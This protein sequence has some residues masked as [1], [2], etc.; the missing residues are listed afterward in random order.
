MIEQARAVLAANDMG[1][2]VRPGKELYPHQWNWDSAFVALGLAQVEP[3]RGRA[4]VR[5][6]LS[7]QWNDGMVPHIVFHVPAP[8]YFPGAELWD[9]AACEQAPEVPTSG[10]TQPPVLASAV[11][12]LAPGVTGPVVPGGGRPRARA[13]ACVVAQRARYRLGSRRHRP[14]VG[15]RGQLAAL[16]PGARAAGSG[17]RR[18]GHR[19]DGQARDRCLGTADRSGLP[20]LPVPRSAIASARLPA[21]PRGVRRSSS[22]ISPSTR[23]SRR[24]SPTSRGS[25]ASSAETALERALPQSACEGAR[26][27]L[28]R[29]RS[30]IRRGRRR[31][32]DGGRDHRRDVPALC[33]CSETGSGAASLRR[34]VV[35]AD[36]LRAFA[37][38]PV[39][40]DLG[41]EIESRVRSTTLLARSRLG[42]RELVLHPGPR[43]IRAPGRGGRAAADDARARQPVRL[44]RV[45]R[46]QDRRAARRQ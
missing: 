38:R 43:A 42:E 9:S 28:G 23:F 34:G 20:A 12:D 8:D 27:P 25:G 37:R 44:R 15:G 40:G 4:E 39:G 24:P 45:L 33:R 7:G 21:H 2:F 1:S 32:D 35:G 16:R 30:G 41:I 26:G 17:R 22:S 31:P 11:R 36:A 18:V 10:L 6:L 14:S 46:P 13:L 29:G 5:S 3:E 19:A